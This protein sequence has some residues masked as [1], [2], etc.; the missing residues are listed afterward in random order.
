MSEHQSSNN[1]EQLGGGDLD[2]REQPALPY[3]IIQAACTGIAMPCRDSV[4]V[5]IITEYCSQDLIFEEKTTRLE[6]GEMICTSIEPAPLN[7][8]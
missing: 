2:S 1:T 6:L 4:N 7:C 5:I 3:I 8:S